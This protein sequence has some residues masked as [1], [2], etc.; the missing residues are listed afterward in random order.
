MRLLLFI[1]LKFLGFLTLVIILWLLPQYRKTWSPY[2]FLVMCLLHQPRTFYFWSWE[3][4]TP[5]SGLEGHSCLIV[6]WTENYPRMHPAQQSLKYYGQVF[7]LALKINGEPMENMNCWYDK[8]RW[9][10]LLINFLWSVHI[11]LASL[12]VFCIMLSTTVW[13]RQDYH[14][15]DCYPIW[16]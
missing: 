8:L 12:P 4:H 7:E 9:L 11:R 14:I 1:A 3:L 6:Q 13:A 2:L 16:H 15:D 5:E 10:I